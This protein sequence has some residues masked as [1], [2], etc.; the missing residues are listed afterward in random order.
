[1]SFAVR[2]NIRRYRTLQLRRYGCRFC[3]TT[4]ALNL[5]QIDVK[6]INT[7]NYIKALVAHVKTC[8]VIE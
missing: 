3:R 8:E 7:R 5:L 2:H 4:L 1:M 6:I